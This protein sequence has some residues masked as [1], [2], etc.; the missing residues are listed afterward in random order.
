MMRRILGILVLVSFAVFTPSFLPGQSQQIPETASPKA[1]L[2]MSVRPSNRVGKRL[3]VTLQIK[4]VG[5]TPFY[6]TKAL[7]S[8]D[9]HGGFDVVVTPPSGA[10]MQGGAAAGDSF[11]K[12]DIIKEAQNSSLL[13]MPGEMYGGTITSMAVPLSPGTYRILGRHAPLAV[14]EDV[15]DKLRTA[16]K[17]PMLFDIIESKPQSVSV[18]K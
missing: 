5:K 18:V 3:T 8:Y 7:E 9:Y 10:R 12:V 15:R 16:L 4:N 14:T 11:G 2:I 1:E 6:I 13:L 17:F